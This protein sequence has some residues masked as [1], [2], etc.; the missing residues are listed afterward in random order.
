MRRRAAVL[1]GMALLA[2]QAIMAAATAAAP[3]PLEAQSLALARAVQAVVAV[4]VEAV[5]GARTAPTLGLVRSGSGVVIGDDDLVL[6]IGY[7]LLEAETVQIETDDG[8]RW[9]ARVRAL[10]P[11]TGFGLVQ[12]LVPLRLPAVP[13]GDPRRLEPSEA[14]TMASGGAEGAVTPARLAHRRDF[15][16]SW[17]Y[18]IESALYTTPPRRDHAGAALFDSRG[19]LLGV[20]SLFVADVAA[21]ARPGAGAGAGSR[22]PGNLFV[23]VDL[24]AP[25]LAELRA[26]GRSAA[27]LRPWLGLNCIEDEG[28][29]RVVRVSEDSPADVAGLEV[30]DVILS[31]DGVPV[32]DLARL[33]KTL[34]AG[35]GSGARAE[36]AV[37]LQ[38]QRGAQR[39]QLTVQAVEREKTLRR[40]AAAL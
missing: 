30:G 5:D 29:V 17:E 7:L 22:G 34:W 31:I 21:G 13:L 11:A 16:A 37:A 4:H 40:P 28:V 20:G 36:R 39:L 12:P 8:R 27:G 25:V 26:Q 32:T 14:L 18:H 1:A 10:D 9:P 33:W 38:L 23:P 35:A 15:A 19:A 3:T 2:P 24:L 6:T